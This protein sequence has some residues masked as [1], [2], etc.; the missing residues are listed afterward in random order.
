M[1]V[2]AVSEVLVVLLYTCISAFSM[3]LVVL[4]CASLQSLGLSGTA[5][6]ISAV[7]MALVVL[8]CMCVIVV[9]EAQWYRCVHRCSPRA[10]IFILHWKGTFT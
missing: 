5:M 10:L 4:L 9:T 1:C 2:I 8:L 7:S 3:V 6:F